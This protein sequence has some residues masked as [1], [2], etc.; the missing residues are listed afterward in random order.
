MRG[1]GPA[2]RADARDP[3]G[4]ECQE[5]RGQ[6]IARNDDRAGGQLRRGVFRAAGEDLQELQLEVAE[7]VGARRNVRVL[8]F[9]EPL[10]GS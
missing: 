3:R 4:I 6:E 5:L 9:A 2:H 10:E 1:R 8:L 7:V